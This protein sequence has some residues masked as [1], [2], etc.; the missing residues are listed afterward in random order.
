MFLQAQSAKWHEPD[1]AHPNRMRFD[2]LLVRLN[3]PSDAAP[4]G[5]GGKRVL[6]TASAAER[7]LPSL[8]G[9]GVDLTAD[10]DG[11][12]ATAKVGVIDRAWIEGDAVHVSG[13]IW[14]GDF[15]QHASRLKL[16]QA[17]LGFSF[18]A[19]KVAVES[20]SADPL[21]I[22][23]L[24]F[25]GAAILQRSLAAFTSTALACAAGRTKE[26]LTVPNELKIAAGAATTVV[27]PLPLLRTLHAAGVNTVGD[28]GRLSE[29]Q[30]E[31]LLKGKDAGAR[32][33]LK[34]QIQA[35]G[36]YPKSVKQFT[37]IAMP[38]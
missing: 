29:D 16:D 25:T 14:A 31:Q 30:L 1:D 32:I 18:E 12:D 24:Q 5:S 7:A 21:V 35:A 6:L 20:P 37:N 26:G 15:P 8:I 10:L 11:H 19:Q 34:G 22:V 9:M 2:G 38:W 4:N 28:D 3:Q 33:A 36:L 27:V 13:S 23:D 17:K